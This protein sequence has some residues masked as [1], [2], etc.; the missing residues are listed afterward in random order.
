MS[1]TKWKH[2]DDPWITK[3]DMDKAYDILYGKDDEDWTDEV[4]ANIKD[5]TLKLSSVD[6]EEYAEYIEEVKNANN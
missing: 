1:I 4:V 3:E 2:I 5:K 6:P